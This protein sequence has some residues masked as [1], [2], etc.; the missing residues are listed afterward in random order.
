MLGLFDGCSLSLSSDGIEVMVG[1]SLIEG[2]LVGRSEGTILGT[3]DG[4]NEMVGNALGVSDRSGASLG[5]CP[6]L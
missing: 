3:D 4:S 5:S 1:I 2:S 6:S